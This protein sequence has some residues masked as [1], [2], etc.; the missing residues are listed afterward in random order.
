MLSVR[1]TVF[2]V[3]IGSKVFDPFRLV[4]LLKVEFVAYVTIIEQTHNGMEKNTSP[5]QKIPLI[6][7]S[8]QLLTRIEIGKFTGYV[9]YI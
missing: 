8:A 6:L 4:L 3:A 1:S 7:K 5:I 2:P 9:V